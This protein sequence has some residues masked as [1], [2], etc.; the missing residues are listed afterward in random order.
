M[1]NPPSTRTIAVLTSGGD[2]PGMNAAVRAVVRT[3]LSRGVRVFA[4][5]E[6]YEG[7]VA[8]GDRIVADD[9]VL[10]R[11]HP[12]H[13]RHRHRHRALGPLPHAR[14]PADG[15]GELPQGRHRQPRGDRR[16][17]KPHRRRHPAA[18][19]AG[20]RSRSWP[21]RGAVD[22]A[23]AAQARP[24]SIVGLAG[25]IDNDMAGTDITIG[26]DT[27]LHRITEAI[28]AIASHRRQPPAHVRGRGH[29]PPLRLPGADG[30]DRHRG[31][32]RAHPGEPA[33]RGRLGGDD[34]RA[35]P[36]RPPGRPPRLDRGRGRGRARPPRE[37]DHRRARP[38]GPAGAARTRTCASPSW[39]TSSG[40]A[41]R[42]RSTA[43]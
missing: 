23:T 40:A 42:A 32:L 24:F 5:R 13:G 18:G 15:G 20:A 43:T 8:G 25:T 39:A 16:R 7:A 37:P 31:E 1:T 9:L 6:G 3:A 30:R 27:A 11:R 22:G 36:H 10:G 33:R 29:G 17:R 12:P 35:P 14:G 19:V 2:A 4:I 26:A 28:D 34:V 21:P 41:R 38:Q